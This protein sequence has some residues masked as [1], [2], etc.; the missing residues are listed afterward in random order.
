LLRDS[1]SQGKDAD[2]FYSIGIYMADGSGGHAVTPVSITDL[3]KG[4]FGLNIYDN[5]WP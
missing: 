1:L 5:N 4:K 3:G 2:T